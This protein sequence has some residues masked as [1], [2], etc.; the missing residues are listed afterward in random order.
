MAAGSVVTKSCAPYS[1]IGGVP[2]KVLRMRFTPEEIEEHE[3]KLV[4]GKR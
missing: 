3:R 2:A 4:K 1:I